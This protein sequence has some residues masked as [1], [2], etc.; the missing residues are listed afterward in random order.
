MK[1]I[2]RDEQK[3]LKKEVARLTEERDILKNSP[4]GIGFPMQRNSLPLHWINA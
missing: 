4:P 3:R 1:G 2:Y